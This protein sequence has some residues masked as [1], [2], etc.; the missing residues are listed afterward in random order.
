V[1][2]MRRQVSVSSTEVHLR[3]GH[4]DQPAPMTKLAMTRL[5]TPHG[6]PRGQTD[7]RLVAEPSQVR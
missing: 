1:A 2:L 3:A 6:V 7:V 5:T 4:G